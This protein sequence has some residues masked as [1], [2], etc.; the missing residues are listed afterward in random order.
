MRRDVQTFDDSLR[1][2]ALTGTRV[3]VGKT[4]FEERD[5]AS[6]TRSIR[7]S[8]NGLRVLAH[9]CVRATEKEVRQRRAGIEF[10]CFQRGVDRSSILATFE[11][12]IRDER[13]DRHRDGIAAAGFAN[14]AQ[15]LVVP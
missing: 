13:I 7:Q 4:R 5:V 6:E 14:L 2:L 1:L 9:F 15:R 11:P 3:R 8:R 12:Y 10:E